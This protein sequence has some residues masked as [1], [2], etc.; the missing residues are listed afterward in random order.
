MRKRACLSITPED[1]FVCARFNRSCDLYIFLFLACLLYLPP[2]SVRLLLF[3]LTHLRLLGSSLSTTFSKVSGYIYIYLYI[4]AVHLALF[5][6]LATCPSAA[7]ALSQLC[8]V[9]KLDRKRRHLEGVAS[10]VLTYKSRLEEENIIFT[11]RTPSPFSSI[12]LFFVLS[13]YLLSTSRHFVFSLTFVSSHFSPFLL[14]ER[15]GHPLLF[16]AL[17]ACDSSVPCSIILR[18]RPPKLFFFIY[19][20]LSL[21]EYDSYCS[22]MQRMSV[23]A[24]VCVASRLPPLS[25][26]L[27]V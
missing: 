2:F 5:S 13:P 11:L 10:F 20:S 7:R 1:F 4:H 19:V 15:L 24:F 26:S 18:S 25:L 21:F 9:E 8:D 27:W 16:F 23:C 17:Q 12:L 22:V 6:L 3:A 14:T